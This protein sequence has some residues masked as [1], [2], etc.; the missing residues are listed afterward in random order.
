MNAAEAQIGGIFEQSG[1]TGE[2]RETGE[3]IPINAGISWT[4]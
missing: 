3:S 4:L 2:I 1:D